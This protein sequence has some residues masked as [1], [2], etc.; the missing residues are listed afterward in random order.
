[1]S[2]PDRLFWLAVY[3]ALCSITAAIKKWKLGDIKNDED[4]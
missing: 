1:M 4:D 3:R 2:E